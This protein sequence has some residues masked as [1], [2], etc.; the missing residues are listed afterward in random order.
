MMKDEKKKKRLRVDRLLTLVAGVF[1]AIDAV[2]LLVVTTFTNASLVALASYDEMHE[3]DDM[4]QSV[5][6]ALFDDTASS[7]GGSAL[8]AFIGNV[9][10]GESPLSQKDPIYV[11]NS[12]V[13][14]QKAF[15]QQLIE[16]TATKLDIDLEEV[17]L[18][19]STVQINNNQSLGVSTDPI[20]VQNVSVQL[21][22]SEGIPLTNVSDETSQVVVYETADK[23]AGPEV[24]LKTDHVVV[25]NGDE[26]NPIT[27]LTYIE[28]QN[29][30]LPVLSFDDSAVNLEEDGIYP[31]TLHAVSQSGAATDVEFEVE[32]KT[33][34]DVIKAR[35][36]AERLAREEEE[37]QERERAA[38]AAAANAYSPSYSSSSYTPP[39]YSGGG[40]PYAG[41]WTNCT[42][43]AW[44]ALYNARGIALP[45]MGNASQWLASAASMG[46]SVGG[47]PAPGSVAVWYYTTSAYGHVAYVSDVS[48]DGSMIYVIEGGYMGA[49]HEGWMAAS[50]NGYI[51]P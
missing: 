42:W 3:L 12:S 31:V 25:N 9:E 46:Y 20:S 32:V 36:E 34:E 5:K 48:A 16:D 41:G 49:Y 17:D 8:V 19:K 7:T 50:A 45:S 30:V 21:K 33:H 26:F 6:T 39:I 24:L 1:F 13:S 38:A 40:N 2:A 44:Q 10:E 28:K 23:T 11:V 18:T 22:D 27:N 14:G 4:L 37:R 43:G 29:D 51:Y 15:K 47:A 35:E